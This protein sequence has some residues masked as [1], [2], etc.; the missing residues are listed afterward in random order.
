MLR[1]LAETGLR[2]PS[3]VRLSLPAHSGQRQPKR[4][5][6]EG[7]AHGAHGAHGTE[8][9]GG[10]ARALMADPAIVL[11]VE[12]TGNLDSATGEAVMRTFQALYAAGIVVFNV[13]NEWRYN[14]YI[15]SR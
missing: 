14:D 4:A 10:A 3:K 5:R 6:E 2:R 11:A 15:I 7:T 9:R 8:G 13:S 1:G 12:P